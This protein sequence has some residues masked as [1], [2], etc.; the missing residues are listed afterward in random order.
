MAHQN[1]DCIY[2]LPAAADLST[3]QH[4]L[5]VVNSSGLVALC[6]A[7][8]H[9]HGKLDNAPLSGKMARMILFY[10]ILKLKAGTGGVTAGAAFVSDATGGCIAGATG[11]KYVGI[12]LETAAASVY[13]TAL[14][15]PGG[16]LGAVP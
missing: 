6:G 12:A 9:P 11:N 16:L 15:L 1:L 3:H 5:I 10:P 14:M 8:A 4:K 2:S 7:G 13:F